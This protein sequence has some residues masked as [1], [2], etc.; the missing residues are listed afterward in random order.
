MLG[1]RCRTP[2]PPH[3][4]SGSIVLT[5]MHCIYKDNLAPYPMREAPPPCPGRNMPCLD[6]APTS[7]L[8]DCI[9]PLLDCIVLPGTSVFHGVSNPDSGFASRVGCLGMVWGDQKYSNPISE[10][11]ESV[12]SLL[13]TDTPCCRTK[14]L[15]GQQIWAFWTKSG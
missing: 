6:Q 15:P 7:M 14:T 10:P 11:M 9:V 5:R 2:P 8:L 4:N 13:S 1:P 12:L 3:T